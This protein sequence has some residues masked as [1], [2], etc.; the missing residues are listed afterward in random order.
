MALRVGGGLVALAA[1]FAMT[2]STMAAR[3]LFFGSIAYLPL[4]LVAMIVSH[5]L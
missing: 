1:R 3:R 5:L 4:L 2:R